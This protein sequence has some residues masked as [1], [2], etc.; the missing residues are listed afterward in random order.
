MGTPQQVM[1][2]QEGISLLT[3]LLT[4]LN[5][6]LTD[7]VNSFKSRAAALEGTMTGPIV[8]AIN[9]GVGTFANTSTQNIAAVHQSITALQRMAQ[10]IMDI[11]QQ[12]NGAGVVPR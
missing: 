2:S 8:N 1:V 10:E 5:G 11:A 7:Q 4:Y 3:D 12:A 6:P 9:E